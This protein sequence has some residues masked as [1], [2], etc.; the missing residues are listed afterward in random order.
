MSAT[1]VAEPTASTATT[2]FDVLIVGAGVAGIGSAVHLRQQCPDK[3]YAIL[4]LKDTFG[5]TWATHQYP[6]IRSDSDLIPMAT[7]SSPGLVRRLPAAKR[8]ANT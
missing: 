2:H 4:D 7:A 5:G 6:G 1:A 8:S 3:T